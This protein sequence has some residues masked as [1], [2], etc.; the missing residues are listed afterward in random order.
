MA[1]YLEKEDLQDAYFEADRVSKDWHKPFSEYERIA[2][3]KLSAALAKNM[4]RVND[5]SLA[6][7]LLETP[8]QVLPMM[9]SGKFTS[10]LRKEA[11]INELANIIWK[12]KIVPNANTQATFFDKEQMALY[13]AIKYGA[14]PRY[15]FYVSTDTYTGCDWSLPYVK[16]VK[17]EPGKFSVDDCDYVFLDIYYT[18]LQL[19]RIIERGNKENGGGWDI[20]QLKILADMSMTSKEM[21][22][23]NINEKDS[24]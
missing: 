3:N 8:M 24:R 18:K 2:G 11:W 19:K 13:R 12:T 5:G 17:L 16:N 6:A 1:V 21:E 9:Q 7:S 23:Q 14:Q 22:E 15:N 10:T 20:A 4:P